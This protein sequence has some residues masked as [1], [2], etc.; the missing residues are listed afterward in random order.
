MQVARREF[1]AAE[2]SEAR[3]IGDDA[4]D[5]GHLARQTF[6]SRDLQVE[7]L[8]LFLDQSIALIDRMRTGTDP[9]QRFRAA[10]TIKGSARGIGAWRVA[11]LAEA[12]ENADKMPGDAARML[13]E[14]AAAIDEANGA[15]RRHLGR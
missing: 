6:G 10:H 8:G 4:V 7:V 1:Q 3:P 13:A 15:I 2:T 11:R 12:V 14:L 9:T 5:F